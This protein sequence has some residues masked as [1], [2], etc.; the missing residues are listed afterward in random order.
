[1]RKETAKKELGAFREQL[2]HEAQRFIAVRNQEKRL[3]V[4]MEEEEKNTKRLEEKALR[5]KLQEKQQEAQLTKESA[6]ASM[7]QQSEA[8]RLAEIRARGWNRIDHT[9]KRLH[10]IPIAQYE[11][12]DA[13]TLLSYAVIIDYSRNLLD[14]LPTHNFL[15]WMQALKKLK[16]SQNHLK[17]L[18]DELTGLGQMESL[19]I[20]S[21]RLVSLPLEFGNLRCKQCN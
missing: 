4:K 14:N 6:I 8:Q 16:L 15:Y 3:Q 2:L 21:N 13:R 12:D 19:E 7:R 20:D 5:T 18:P 11:T 9:M 17:Y 10:H 1:M